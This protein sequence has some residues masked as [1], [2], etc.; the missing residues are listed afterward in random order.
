MKFL[1]LLGNLWATF[2]HA[3]AP[4]LLRIDLHEQ[5]GGAPIFVSL[6]AQP[7]LPANLSLVWALP[8]AL[9]VQTA[10]QVLLT[11]PTDADAT[12]SN[13]TVFDSGLVATAAQAC[14]TLARVALAPAT[15]YDFVVMVTALGRDGPMTSSFS[16]PLRFL[17][18]AGPLWAASE[19]VWATKCKGA[20]GDLR[21]HFAVL[22]ADVPVLVPAAANGVLSALLYI[23]AAP[24]VSDDRL[25][26]PRS[27]LNRTALISGFKLLV[28]AVTLGIGPG[29]SACGPFANGPCEPVQPVDGFDITQFARDAAASPAHILPLQVKAYSVAQ[30]EFGTVPA[31]QVVLIVR[32]SPEGASPD[33]VFGTV[34]GPG[35]WAALDGD[36]AF[37][38]TG[39]V[40]PGWYTQPREDGDTSCLPGS[41]SSMP[42]ATC[43]GAYASCTWAPPAAAPGAFD[44]VANGS[45]LPLAAKATQAVTVA[46]GVPFAS[47]TQLGPGWWVLDAGVE[48]MGGVSLRLSPLASPGVP[49]RAT[50]Q[51][52]DELL[53]NGST[54]WI[55]RSGMRY[56]SSWTFPATDNP[57][58]APVH[59]AN[60]HHEM[61][62]FRYVEL[63]LQ[64]VATGAPVDP[65]L[66]LVGATLWVTRYRYDDDGS[67]AVTTTDVALDSVFRF[68]S[69]TLKTT[70]M[71][72]YA[73][74]YTRQR[75][76]DCM[77][78]D[79]VAAL[80]HYSTTTE[81]A[82][83]R[84]MAAQIMEIGPQGLIS[85]SVWADWT[86]IPGLN[87]AYDVL[88][89]GDL[90][91][92]SATFDK[93]LRNHTYAWLI[94]PSLGLIKASWL[95]ALID[96]SGGSD[97]GFVQS[98]VNAVVNAWCYLAMRRTAQ[99]GRSIGRAADAAQLDATADALQAAF[100]RLLFNG[101]AICDGL[102][103][104]TPHTSVH[105]T[106]YA[107]WAG[108]ARGNDTLTTALAG[109][110]RARAI[111]DP[112]LGVP[113]GSYPVQFLLLALYEDSFDHG[114]AAHGVLTAATKHSW[115][116]MM[117]SFGAT[118]T[119]ECWLP[120]ELPNLS[121]SHVWSSS[122]AIVVP[123]C[124]FGVLPTSPGFAT[125]DVKPQP[126]PVESGSASLPSVRGP[127]GVAFKQT[128]PGAAGGCMTV[129]V[130]VPG[131]AVARIGLPRWGNASTAVKL[132]G[133]DTATTF[134]GDFAVI[135]G[136]GA[137]EHS[138]TTC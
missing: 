128:V 15:A 61:C 55:A 102:C 11:R 78:D 131:G 136:V 101:S 41:I 123:H 59:L 4:V 117:Q 130:T 44:N 92:A 133:V 81:L 17:T 8:P 43:A 73:D 12:A 87:V 39:N 108:L 83:P 16:A 103:S 22:R 115:V 96:T 111:E 121:F 52:A 45:P 122:P 93:L 60:E 34:A 50:I 26:R 3:Q 99:L 72:L 89:S 27:G 46:E 6:D 5:Q 51:L 107:L 32:F 21:P 70:S 42:L 69:F 135:G 25:F 71:D 125:F 36:G 2:G 118:S 53:V 31:I 91:L 137:G 74:S 56:Q 19:P 23:T 58:V 57:S 79:N 28:N 95:S 132:D 20:P 100:Q 9:L 112:V 67:A 49:V 97:D 54:R 116:N 124:F 129:D 76:F 1:L 38:F 82:V 48:L 106:F 86:V 37:V 94:D 40:D 35:M 138:A 66:A 127:I 126:G 110:V 113:C 68:A 114:N 30:P 10:F 62:Q 63:L 134:E 77:A 109:Y 7:G 47:A 88:Y 75:S 18:G 98:P 14:G 84:A 105:S 13:V 90:T 65:F 33:A 29:H 104:S 80:S 64:D 120:E 85:D 119:M 24:L